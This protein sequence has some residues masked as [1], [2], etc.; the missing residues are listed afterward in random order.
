MAL[1]AKIELSWQGV[2]YP[3]L[4]TMEVIDRVDD[5]INLGKMLLRNLAKDTRY[6]HSANLLSLMLNEAGAKVTQEEI[7][8][9]MFSSEG[10]TLDDVTEF[11]EIILCACFFDTKKKEEATESK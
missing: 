9:T 11:N 1:R 2:S 7:H 10:I 4:V 6:S 8:E 5:K 3:L